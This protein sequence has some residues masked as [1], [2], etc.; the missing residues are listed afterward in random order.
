VVEMKD[1]AFTVSG[2]A[3]DQAKAQATRAA[4][5]GALPSGFTLSDQIRVREPVKATEPKA[6]EGKPPET[7]AAELKSPEPPPPE[8]SA[9]AALSAPPQQTPPPAQPE[10][11]TALAPPAPP[12]VS[13][14]AEVAAPKVPAASPTA[15]PAAAPAAPPAKTAAAP[16]PAP[17]SPAELACQQSLQRIVSA[18]HILFATDSATLDPS[19]FDTLDRLSVAAKACPGMRIAIEGHTDSEGT[20]DYNQRL[21]VRRAQAVVAY[22]TKAGAD[23]RQL[24]AVGYGVS[25]PAVPNDTLENMAKNRRI[26]FN[27]RQQ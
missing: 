10:P 17:L 24:E 13:P 6:P 3:I 22:L 11:K 14:P 21:S 23:R 27:V 18:G 20:A 7:K 9:S 8:P 15:P 19:S 1:T 25:R 12:P 16:A 2:V 4:L 5:R 26:E